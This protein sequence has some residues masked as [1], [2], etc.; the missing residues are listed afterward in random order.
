MCLR[1]GD[2]QSIRN[3]VGKLSKRQLIGWIIANAIDCLPLNAT[4]LINTLPQPYN[5]LP[6]G[7]LMI[8]VW[9]N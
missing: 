5:H 2:S 6:K 3:R 8:W 1:I 7:D 9:G 4:S